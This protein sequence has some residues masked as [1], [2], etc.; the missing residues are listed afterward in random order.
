MHRHL[1]PASLLALIALLTSSALATAA[2]PQ[3][4]RAAT[5]PKKL[6]VLLAFDTESNLSESLQVDRKRMNACLDR[7]LKRQPPGSYE[8]KELVGKNATRGEILAYFR[9]PK[10]K[11]GP[12]TALVFI[13]GGHGVTDDKLGHCLDLTY[14]GPLVRAELRQAM[15]KRNPRLAVLLTDCCSTRSPN[16]VKTKGKYDDVK[17]ATRDASLFNAL[18]MESRGTVDITAA[19][20]NASWGDDV[21]GGLFTRVLCRQ[22]LAPPPRSGNEGTAA[23]KTF[24]NKLQ[25]ATEDE[26]QV[27]KKQVEAA[28]RGT[29]GERGEIVDAKT[30]KPQA[31]VLPQAFAVVGLANK[32]SQPFKIEYRWPGQKEWKVTDVPVNGKVPLFV[33]VENPGAEGGKLE[34]RFAGNDRVFLVKSKLWKGRG[35]PSFAD[36]QLTEIG[37]GK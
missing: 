31:Y 20:G 4:P 26:F 37:R 3:A 15:E 1:S 32:L 14:G 6:C 23:W 22:L 8:V 10:L 5:E 25:K 18:F 21:N 28:D 24:F 17:T 29:E 11:V 19:T 2:D 12:E 9:D 7:V 30:Q 13:Y 35:D 27:W 34:L 33:E 16:P 36:G